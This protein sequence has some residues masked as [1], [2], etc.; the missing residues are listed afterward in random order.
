MTT[1]KS[2]ILMT[3]AAIV[4]LAGCFPILLDVNK[5]GQVLIPRKEG[6]FVYDLKTDKIDL[7]LKSNGQADPAWARWSPDASMALVAAVT[8]DNQTIFT[9]VQVR[10]KRAKELGQVGQVALAIW[11]PDGK[12]F[13]FVEVGMG[14]GGL[15]AMD[16]ASGKS[17][18]LL[19]GASATHA[20][21][22]DSKT[23]V[24]IKPAENE[25]QDDKP[26]SL[27]LVTLDGKSRKI[28]EVR[29]EGN[30]ALSLSPDGKKLV[31]VES[32]ED[33]DRLVSISL[34]DGRKTPVT[35][36]D[37][38]PKAAFFSP[39][40]SKLALTTGGENNKSR[41]VILPNGGKPIVVDED[42]MTSTGGMNGMP[43]YPTWVDEKT[44]LYFKA[45]PA[46]GVSG[47]SMHL[48]KATIG[49]QSNDLQLTID[50]GVAGLMKK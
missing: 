4:L 7:L 13:S 1:R 48:V 31:L 47:V 9:A 5:D 29:T 36:G 30:S 28:A 34:P 10:S 32:G 39:D 23:I 37:L 49:G 6:V 41:L 26:A 24:A 20:W 8:P 50:N 40:G 21:L 27:M 15:K 16:P 38:E 46:Y 3:M 14:D 35:L 25:G 33:G 11:S 44:I 2:G 17:Q 18:M 12:K 22:P 19:E 42:I 43:V 45:V